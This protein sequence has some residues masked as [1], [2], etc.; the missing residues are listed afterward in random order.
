MGKQYSVQKKLNFQ[1]IKAPLRA[2]YA[3]KFQVFH[4]T[5]RH[6]SLYL[7]SPSKSNNT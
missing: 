7:P 1:N 3:M 6:F 5:N 4:V 2:Q